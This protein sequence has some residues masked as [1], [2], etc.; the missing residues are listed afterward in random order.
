MKK[1]WI[2]LVAVVLADI[3]SG[4]QVG[5]SQTLPPST[6]PIPSVTANRPWTPRFQDFNGV[7]MALV[8]PG[9][10]TMGSARGAD[11]QKPTQPPCFSESFWIDTT[12]VTQAQFKELGGWS[13]RKP[14]EPG[15]K[16]PVENV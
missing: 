6:T 5:Q 11:D 8:P 9:C 12:D 16:R 15:D 10:F 14:D 3:V 7:T 1:R 2:I 4:P 13:A